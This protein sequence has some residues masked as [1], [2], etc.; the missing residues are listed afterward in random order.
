M[1]NIKV[2]AAPA[3]EKPGDK[4]AIEGTFYAEESEIAWID[5]GESSILEFERI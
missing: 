4:E 5:L 2:K 3:I 1:V